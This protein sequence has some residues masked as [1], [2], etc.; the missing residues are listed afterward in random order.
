MQSPDRASSPSHS[1]LPAAGGPARAVCRDEPPSRP[2][3]PS[4]SLFA[5]VSSRRPLLPP[6]P[7]STPLHLRVL[8]HLARLGQGLL[9][10]QATTYA[11]SVAYSAFLSLFP[12]L[13]LL[14][15]IGGRFAQAK[16]VETV[17]EPVIGKLPSDVQALLVH[18]V[19]RLGSTGSLAPAATAGFLWVVSSGFHAL[20]DVLEIMQGVVARPYWKKR[21]FALAVTVGVIVGLIIAGS[22]VVV[23]V[24]VAPGLLIPWLL[25]LVASSLATFYRIAVPVTRVRKRRLWPG[26]AFATLVLTVATSLFGLYVSKLGKF[27]LYYGSV[28]TVAV[29]LFWLWL[30]SLAILA[31]AELNVQLEDAEADRERH[32]LRR[33]ADET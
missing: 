32:R 31:G 2:R 7:L 16:G 6:L 28:A 5:V 15:Y 3:I 20:F 23:F 30:S 9:V 10:H 33:H 27:A 19:E 22:V 26:A 18:E 4:T 21:A 24:K 25:V 14:G 29:L 11:S 1:R 8:R 17:L 13:L 12:L